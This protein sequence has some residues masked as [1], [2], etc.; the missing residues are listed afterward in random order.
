MANQRVETLNDLAGTSIGEDEVGKS[1][2]CAETEAWYLAVFEGRGPDK[3]EPNLV[4][5]RPV[6]SA[7]IRAYQRKVRWDDFELKA[8]TQVTLPLGAAFPEGTL[9]QGVSVNVIEQFTDGMFETAC[10]MG[11][12][13]ALDEYTPG[14]PLSVTILGPQAFALASLSSG[15]TPAITLATQGPSFADLGHGEL[16]ATIYHCVPLVIP[17]NDYARLGGIQ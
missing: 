6:S 15:K 13:L 4:N 9:V 10:V 2:Y 16:V 11:T 7:G 3:W 1:F 12:T 5:G 8:G 14:G 17:Q